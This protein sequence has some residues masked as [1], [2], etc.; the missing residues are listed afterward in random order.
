[1]LFLILVVSFFIPLLAAPANA[2]KQYPI[3]FVN[4][5]KQAQDR[6]QEADNKL[7]GN[8]ETIAAWLVQFRL[9]FGHFPEAGVEQDKA[10][11]YLQTRIIKPNPYTQTGIASAEESKALCPLRF[12]CESNLNESK[13]LEWEKKAPPEWRAEPGSITVF[14]NQQTDLVIW[15]AGADHLPVVDQ[16]NNRSYLAWRT[17]N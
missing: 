16:K 6:R 13:R 11:H 9:K 14:I 5:F 3:N 15:G 7:I 4:A 12:I 2:Q 17:L 8:M 1:M 10:L